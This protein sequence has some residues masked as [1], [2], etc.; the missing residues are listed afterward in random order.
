MIK[1]AVS[2]I[3]VAMVGVGAVRTAWADY[4]AGLRAY[5]DGNY[6]TAASEFRPL[7]DD[8]DARAQYFLGVMYERG[9]GVPLDDAQAERWYSAAAGLGS[10]R[11][12]HSIREVL[13]LFQGAAERGDAR[14]HMYVGHMYKFSHGAPKDEAEAARWY[15]KAAEMF[16]EAADRGDARAHDY[17][18]KMYFAGFGVERDRE[19]AIRWRR[20]AAELRRRAAEQGDARSQTLVGHWYESSVNPSRDPVAATQWYRKA[21]EQGDA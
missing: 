17:L 20:S 5:R 13:G 6:A 9:S 1:Y 12:E 16:R 21:A 7:A 2:T 8:G 10:E 3:L 4:G 19:E 15:L 11:A 18:S 14:A